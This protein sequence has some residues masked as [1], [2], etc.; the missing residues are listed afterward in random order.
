MTRRETVYLQ[1]IIQTS[2][3]VKLDFISNDE[4]DLG[5]RNMLNFGHC[6]GHAIESVSN[7]DIPHGQGVVCGMILANYVAHQR[8]LLSQENQVFYE[9]YLLNPCLKV[10][11]GREQ[12]AAPEIIR[13][14]EKD[15]KRTGSGLVLVMM[16]DRD[17]EL[18]RVNDLDH[19][20]VDQ[21]IKYFFERKVEN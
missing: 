10:Q 14:M 3:Q 6:F 21:A 7:F 1:E 11:P 19:S 12:M 20:E 9:Q 15:K 2:L 18:L 4:F 13:A 17:G 16:T 5:R 8:G